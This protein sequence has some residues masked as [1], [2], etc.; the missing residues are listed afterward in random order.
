L[1]WDVCRAASKAKYT[2]LTRR[3]AG[4]CE[5]LWTKLM[6]EPLKE[7]LENRDWSNND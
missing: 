2:A 1:S 5:M 7:I 6:F 3:V 4:A